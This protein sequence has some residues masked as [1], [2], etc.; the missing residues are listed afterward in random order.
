MTVQIVEAH[1]IGDK[2][3]CSASSQELKEYGWQAACGNLPSAY[4]T[5][6]LCGIRG[7]GKNV[8]K[9]VAD[10]GL[11]QPSRGARIFASLKGVVDAGINVPHNAAKLPDENRL[12]G[13]HISDYAQKLASSDPESYQKTFSQYLERQLPPESIPKHFD[14]TKEKILLPLKKAPARRKRRKREA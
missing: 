9:A 2:V 13:R 10:I 11:H 1:P 8:N 14:A 12:T 3:V 6:L 7:K 4:L 5:G